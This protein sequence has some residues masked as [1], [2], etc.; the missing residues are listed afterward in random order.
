MDINEIK[1]IIEADKGKF[2]IV[3]NGKPIMV[4]VSFEDYKKIFQSNTA[5][6]SQ[7]NSPQV[8]KDRDLTI[9]DLPF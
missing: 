6:G 4:I 5:V 8:Q 7:E 9:E 2:I 1:N 3:E